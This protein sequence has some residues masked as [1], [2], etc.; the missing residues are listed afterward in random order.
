M[1]QLEDC[2]GFSGQ[3]VTLESVLQT[4]REQ[5]NVETVIEITLRHLKR[6]SDFNLVWIGLC[7]PAKPILIGQGGTAPEDT[8][9]L[10]QRIPISP[11]D[12]LDQV[13]VQ[14]RPIG[15]PDLRAES[16]AGEWRKAAE[17]LNIQGTILFPIR[18]KDHSFGL[19]LLGSH[20]WG[21]SPRAGEMAKLLMLLRALG[22]VL[23]QIEVE[24]QRQRAKRSD[25]PLLALL[26][27]LG[28]L[29]NLT[30][31][32]EAVVGQT[33]QF[34]DPARTSI[35]W[36]E[37]ERGCFRPRVSQAA[38]GNSSRRGQQS[39]SEIL[40]QDISGFYQAMSANQMVAVS[41]AQSM[42]KADVTGRLMQQ[43]KARSL[44]AAPVLS[45]DE[46][47]GFL[48]VE[49]SEPRIWEEA[50][51]SYLR[52]AA[53]LVGLTA[54]LE[55]LE[56]TIWQ[57]QRD[58][59]L[60]S[61]LTR[62][63]YT[64]DDWKET[65]K[66][67]ANQ[68]CKHLQAERLLVLLLNPDTGRF[69]VC[70]QQQGPQGRPLK[71]VLNPLSS[72]DWQMLERSTEAIAIE[73]LPDNL[74]LMAWRE[75]LL[76]LGA[77]SL[78][79]CSTC[80]G[81]PL[82][83][84][85]VI[86]DKTNRSWRPQDRQVV[87]G[88]SQQL[89]LILHQWQLQRQNN[90]QQQIQQTTQQG[91]VAIQQTRNLVDLE[92]VGL[93]QITQ[94]LQVPL[95]A[96]VRWSPG[97]DH[98]WIITPP[99][100][101]KQF[102]LQTETAISLTDPLIRLALEPRQQQTSSAMHPG[103][104]LLSVEDLAPET[105]RWLIG[106]EIGQIGVMALQTAPEHLPAGIVLVADKRG[107][108]W[109]E[110]QLGAFIALVN[111]LAWSYRTIQLATSLQQK[112]QDL[113]CLN[114]YR[115]RRLE[116][117]Y[118]SISEGSDQLKELATQQTSTAD[119]GTIPELTRVLTGTETRAAL[120]GPAEPGPSLPKD[121]YQ[122]VAEQ[123][124]GA[125]AAMIALIE[126]DWQLRVQYEAVV[127]PAFLKRVFDRVDPWTRQ[128]Q[129]WLQVH[130][131]ANVTLRGDLGKIEL[132][133]LE[134]LQAACSRSPVGGRID[135]WSQVLDQQQL[136]L[137]IT[138]NGT[139]APRLLLELQ[140]GDNRDVL[141]PSVLEQPPGRYLKICRTVIQQLG[142]QLKTSQLA[143]GRVLNQLILPLTTKS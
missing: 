52:G 41:E 49:G 129:L 109:S 46:L 84:L 73:N 66:Q 18:Y 137:L 142:G 6:E 104:R 114:W 58:Q 138:D 25:Q 89:G 135:I 105:R 69:E 128:R 75:A 15:V 3:L 127:L 112:T 98:G 54:P 21:V 10:K 102:A 136:E 12:L 123:L 140:Q 45:Q 40:A 92:Q 34:I 50:E 115:Q 87:Q 31:R 79:V 7:D 70:H 57:T 133:L 19:A 67:S 27:K 1:A 126:E 143:D 5:E 24:T 131:R 55:K 62:A 125:L 36:F 64:D 22:A 117:I 30:Q 48:A 132:I 100:T 17:K 63:I 91:I 35:Y 130:N 94:L 118:R 106:A 39:S 120:A 110:L 16:R 107:R 134:L 80:I 101:S 88:V 71:E 139:L 23:N 8:P 44:L 76:E 124:Q 96:V 37:P 72:V 85:L 78:L 83:G 103:L 86:C 29:P 14:Q 28:T 90:Q 61:G 9:L 4:L 113:E 116:A 93:Q 47:L 119:T 95:A 81:R 68:L 20:L 74:K 32:L 33:H 43:L 59:L 108:R 141:A 97:Q 2:S 122:S 51:K 99:T 38:T 53:Q 60:Q 11:G 26:A 65:L 56:K 111:Q 121:S 13:L 82:E 77:R 42:L